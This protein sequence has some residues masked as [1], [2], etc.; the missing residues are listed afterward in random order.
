MNDRQLDLF[1]KSDKKCTCKSKHALTAD[2]FDFCLD[3]AQKLKRLILD[4]GW[5]LSKNYFFY[6]DKLDNS[7][8]AWNPENSDYLILRA[9][10]QEKTEEAKIPLIRR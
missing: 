8:N 7:C 1:I 6:M 2:E 10:Y 9:G 4:H 5:E 3:Q